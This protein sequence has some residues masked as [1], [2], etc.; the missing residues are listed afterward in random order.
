[1]ADET[2]PAD[3]GQPTPEP[4]KPTEGEKPAT[5]SPVA[6]PPASDTP[7]PAENGK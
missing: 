1:M 4:A 7:A 5:E 6:T 3:A 2:K